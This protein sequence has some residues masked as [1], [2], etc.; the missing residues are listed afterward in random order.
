MKTTGTF[1]TASR[2]LDGKL[3]ITF[4]ID[5][6]LEVIDQLKEEGRLMIT[7]KP[8]TADKT[9]AM[10]RYFWELCTKIAFKLHT[11]KESIYRLQLMKH[12][13]AQIIWI[14]EEAIPDLMRKAGFRHYTIDDCINDEIIEAHFY[15]GA[16]KMDKAEFLELLDGTVADCYE[17]GID[18]RPDEETA[19]IIAK[20]R[21]RI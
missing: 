18:P 13:E 16:S 3:N 11:D 14:K 2:D 7:T 19:Q 4:T 9:L 12:S 17:I 5:G 10:N 6:S 8:S 1:K 20:W 15:Y 21:R